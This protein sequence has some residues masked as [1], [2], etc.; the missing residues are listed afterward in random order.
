MVCV[1]SI[2]KEIER[3]TEKKRLPGGHSL[4]IGED[5]LLLFQPLPFRIPTEHFEISQID[6]RLV[7]KRVGYKITYDGRAFAL[8]E[9]DCQDLQPCDIAGKF[10]EWLVQDITELVEEHRAK[11]SGN[12]LTSNGL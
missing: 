1:D 12:K 2:K 10:V 6:A 3:L 11:V 5:G 9:T 8:R 7:S 4:F